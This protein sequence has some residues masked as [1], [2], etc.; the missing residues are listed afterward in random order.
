MCK[1]SSTKKCLPKQYQEF[2]ERAQPQ[3]ETVNKKSASRAE[4]T[5]ASEQIGTDALKAVV[6]EEQGK[7]M[8]E[9]DEE[10]DEFSG[11]GVFDAVVQEK[12]GRIE[13]GEAK[14]GSS[15]YGSRKVA[16]SKK[17]VNQCTVP[18][19]KEEAKVMAR[20]NYKGRHP[21]RG[22]GRHSTFPRGNC[23]MCR[24]V[25]RRRRKETGKRVLNAM[26][27]GK[28]R[29][30]AVRGGYKGKCLEVPKVIDRYDVT[31]SG[32]TIPVK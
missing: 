22:C 7:S 17:R 4:K 8:T 6:A 10:V 5:K 13:V 21:S 11:S 23:P 29:K 20:S 32:K 31:A 14:G 24:N 27:S 9:V 19:M 1:S 12:G 18:Y 16:G 25:E 2:E 15:R 3:L 28:V 26:K 30:L